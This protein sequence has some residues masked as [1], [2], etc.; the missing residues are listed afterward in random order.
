MPDVTRFAGYSSPETLGS[1]PWLTRE[2][3]ISGLSTWRGIV[4]RLAGEQNSAACQRLVREID[5][6]LAALDPR[7]D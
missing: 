4:L 2:D 7:E 5:R 1:D 3:K 6:V